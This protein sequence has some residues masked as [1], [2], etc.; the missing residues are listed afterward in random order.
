MTITIPT[1]SALPTAP[2]RTDPATFASRGDAFVA[3]LATLRAEMNTTTA[4]IKTE[5]EA[6][7]A[8]T[9]AALARVG[10]PETLRAVSITGTPSTIDF[11]H[12]VSGVVISSAYDVYELE[13]I[14]VV[15]SAPGAT[16]HARMSTDLGVT[17]L[18]GTFE[19]VFAI[20][21]NSPAGISNVSS[22]AATAIQISG[23]TGSANSPVSGKVVV[24][25]PASA[26][27]CYL[28]VDMLVASSLVAMRVT[29]AGVKTQT[30]DVDGIRIYPSAGTFVSGTVNFKAYRK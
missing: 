22:T 28:S 3:A 19:Y 4:A 25:A 18:Q 27:A 1:I 29:G 30:I 14:N 10:Y 6:E 13:L 5:V 23:P 9:S 2:S 26:A 17:F 16:L 12:G 11:V 24:Y 8:A 21:L 20:N 15:L 7:V